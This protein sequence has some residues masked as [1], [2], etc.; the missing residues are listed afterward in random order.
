MK[1]AL[2]VAAALLCAACRKA[3][4]DAPA[5]PPAVRVA[6]AEAG[7]L[8]EWLRLPGRVVPPPDRDATLSLRTE[9][10]LS[11][12]R[13]RVGERVARGAVLAR[14]DA[15]PLADVLSAADAATKGAAA[16]AE[17]KRRVANR[18]RNLVTRG[19]ISGEQAE[20]DEAA[21]LA[22]EAALAQ[23]QSTRASASRRLGWI[24]LVAPFD[25]VVV[26][27]LKQAGESVDGTAATAVVELA[28]EHPVEVAL[29]APASELSRLKVGQRAEIV[30][31]AAQAAPIEA[32]VA[33]VAAAVDATT[34]TG[35]VRLDPST[36]DAA[37]LLGRVVNARIAVATNAGAIV[38]PATALRGGA[39]EAVVVVD[40]KARVRT[41]TT[42]IRD[43]DRV[44]VVSGLAPGDLVVVDDPVGLADGAD[45]RDGP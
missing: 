6:P 31:D 11:E 4:A 35:P 30:V 41:V 38:V 26:R 25:G 33:G 34:G 43:G 24:E 37:L 45:V 10:I 36:E 21:A 28:A 7:T 13:A 39:V 42:G 19:V 14:V 1:I 44:E 23:A 12:V 18:S 17:A 29:D 9:G 27:V 2:A 16:E 20:T 3:P 32:R 15:A 5:D 22:A 40:H 8:T